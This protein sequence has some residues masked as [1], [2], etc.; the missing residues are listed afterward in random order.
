PMVKH[1]G[2]GFYLGLGGGAGLPAEALREGYDPGMAFVAPI[3]WDSPTSP[4]GFR[5]NL[6]YTRLAARNTFRSTGFVT[7]PGVGTTTTS[8]V[9]TT[10]PQIW[11]AMAD[12]KLRMP[13][14]GHFGGNSGSG[15]YVI[16]GGGVNHFRNYD[17]SL[18]RTNP[19]FDMDATT[20]TVNESLTRAAW[21]AGA[22]LSIGV[23]NT[24]V[25]LESRYVSLVT[26]SQHASF[27]PITVGVTFY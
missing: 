14:L 23:H 22:G 26:D 25:F 15:L 5:V 3:G 20:G 21:N 2:N 17:R 13:F 4:L 6:G 12:L 7:G 27:I 1:Y 10:D 19:G 11:S 16:G 9:A 8:T 18:Q 24:A